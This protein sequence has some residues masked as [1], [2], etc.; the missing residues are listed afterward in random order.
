M[1]QAIE[2]W[3]DQ[4]AGDIITSKND[5]VV[6]TGITPSGH[7]HIGNMREV[8]TAD[9]VV[10]ALKE[11]GKSVAFNYVADTFDPLRKVYPFLDEK[12]YAQFVGRPLSEIPAPD[13][14]SNSYA[15]YF[16]QPFLR[17]LKEL[18]I[19]VDVVRADDMYKSGKYV[20]NIIK[21]LKKTDEIKKNVKRYHRQANGRTLVSI[22]TNLR[23][24]QKHDG[25][26]GTWF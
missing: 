5:F 25:Q 23:K 3:A 15:D 12:K 4:I 24:N 22:C 13:G 16:L 6:S 17:S 1:S 8:V 2:F 10:K 14:S 18:D 26:S 19:C 20:E 7:I 21:A 11:K 9:A